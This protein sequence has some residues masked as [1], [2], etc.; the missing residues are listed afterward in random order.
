MLGTLRAGANSPWGATES[1]S[2][3]FTRYSPQTLRVVSTAASS[4]I[5]IPLAVNHPV[6]TLSLLPSG[7]AGF[8][9]DRRI[10]SHVALC[11]LVCTVAFTTL[12]LFSPVSSCLGIVFGIL[13]SRPPF[14]V[15][16]TAR[17]VRFIFTHFR[18]ILQS[19]FR[20]FSLRSLGF[21][22]HRTCASAVAS[23][24]VLP[25]CLYFRLI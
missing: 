6:V 4:S 23:V 21:L 15:N 20:C 2:P 7:I 25:A 18:F 11:I 19:Y 5:W 8:F 22:A 3:I 12:A 16:F 13:G 10:T 14:P 17:S 9:W 1:T 24:R